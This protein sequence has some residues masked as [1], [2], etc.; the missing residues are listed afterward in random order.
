M[1][2]VKPYGTAIHEAIAAGDLEKMREVR[3]AAREH[4][5]LAE[6]VE[7]LDAEIAKMEAGEAY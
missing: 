7:K 5:E 4:P 3:E 2:G 6:H 1:A